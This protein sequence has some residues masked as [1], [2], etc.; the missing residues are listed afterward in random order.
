MREI[1]SN[2][3]FTNSAAHSSVTDLLNEKN[4]TEVIFLSEV[5]KRPEEGSAKKSTLSQFSQVR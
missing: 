5:E 2:G 4:F 1:L 3:A